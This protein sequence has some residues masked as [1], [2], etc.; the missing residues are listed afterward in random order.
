MHRQYKIH[1]GIYYTIYTITSAY[2]YYTNICTMYINVYNIG[3]SSVQCTLYTIVIFSVC[4][5]FGSKG[6]GVARW[7]SNLSF[8]S[9][10]SLSPSSLFLSVSPSFPLYDIVYTLY[11]YGILYIHT[12]TVRMLK[13]INTP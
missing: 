3:R 5:N 8:T 10:L 9:S 7:T 1:I 2:V 13:Y 6:E 4:L 12:N 11:V